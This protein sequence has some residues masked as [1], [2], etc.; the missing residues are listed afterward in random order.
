MRVHRW[1]WE[2]IALLVYVVLATWAARWGW[3]RA[4]AGWVL[5]TFAG[6]TRY[7]HGLRLAEDA[8]K[9]VDYLSE[10]ATWLAGLGALLATTDVLAVARGAVTLLWALVFTRYRL[11][12][13]G[14]L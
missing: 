13:R 14:K 3:D 6:H 12:L 4:W 5:V 9:S 2:N 7:S 10:G 8:G 1:V 11:S